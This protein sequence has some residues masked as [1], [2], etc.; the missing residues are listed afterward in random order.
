VLTFN[1]KEIVVRRSK[2]QRTDSHSKAR[3][4][5]KCYRTAPQKATN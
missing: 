3:W 2:T 5:Q 1:Y 4:R